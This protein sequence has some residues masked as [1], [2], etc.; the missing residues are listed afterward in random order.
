MKEILIQNKQKAKGLF[1]T[2]I[3][4]MTVTSATNQGR[5]DKHKL[6]PSVS[7]FARS[8]SFIFLFLFVLPIKGAE[9]YRQQTTKRAETRWM[10]CRSFTWLP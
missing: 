1:V 4:F 3:S 5:R 9:K 7:V 10:S 6:R 8:C 2:S